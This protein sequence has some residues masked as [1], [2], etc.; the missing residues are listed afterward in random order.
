MNSRA[1]RIC[2]FDLLRQYMDRVPDL[3]ASKINK[4]MNAGGVVWREPPASDQAGPEQHRWANLDFLGR[5]KAREAWKDYWPQTG[6]RFPWDAVGRVQIGKVG[7]EWRPVRAHAKLTELKRASRGSIDCTDRRIASAI[8]QAQ[9]SFKAKPNANWLKSDLDL[10]TRLS[11]LRFLRE[12]SA[13][14][15][16]LFIYFYNDGKSRS[17]VLPTLDE[18]RPAIATADRRLG[19]TG[20]SVLERRIYRMFLPVIRD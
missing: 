16:M 4:A 5:G 6:S 17:K 15:R 1:T 12:H 14:V 20:K 8:C 11:A 10:A 18:W 9:Q 2:G 13:C 7:W 3:L 19:L